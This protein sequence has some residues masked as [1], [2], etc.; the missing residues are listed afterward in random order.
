M[1]RMSFL[2]AL[3]AVAIVAS[4]ASAAVL[5]EANFDDGTSTGFYATGAAVVA[6]GE[7]GSGYYLQGNRANYYPTIYAN[8]AGM[9]SQPT[10]VPALLGETAFVVSVDA[11]AISLPTDSGYA[12]KIGSWAGTYWQYTHA[13]TAPTEWTSY[14]LTIDTTWTD[15]EAAA[16]GWVNT[17]G[18]QSW[19][20]SWSALDVMYMFANTGSTAAGTYQTGIDNFVIT[21]VPEPA[22]MSLLAAGGLLGLLKRRK[23]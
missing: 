15:A 6:P 18:S 23:K 20:D 7:G 12:W 10:D 19:T 3:L 2:L 17:S 21:D 9:G 4:S 8:A 14:S 22:T 13:A 11:K 5:L 1:R 16:A